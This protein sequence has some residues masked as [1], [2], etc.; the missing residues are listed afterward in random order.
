M[1][2]VQSILRRWWTAAVFLVAG[3]FALTVNVGV[4]RPVTGVVIG[5]ALLIG[6]L[7]VSPALFPRSPT[8]AEAQEQAT[9]QQAPLIFWKPGCTYCLRVAVCAGPG[10]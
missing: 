2:T 5:A 7:V 8:L 10:R 3:V 9:S 4:G 6:A 1:V